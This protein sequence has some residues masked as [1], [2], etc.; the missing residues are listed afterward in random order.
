MIA[1]LP[2][3]MHYHQFPK[4]RYQGS[5]RRLLPWLDKTF[6]K[7]E[8][9]SCLDIFGGTSSVSYLLKSKGKSVSYNDY[10]KSNA[11][12]AKAL[13]MNNSVK[14]N[15]DVFDSLFNGNR[16]PGL[17]TELFDGIFYTK[18][19]NIEIDTIINMINSSEA[20]LSGHKKDIA[21]FCLFQA[22]LMKRPFNLFH[23]ANLNLRTRK[24]KRSFGNHVTW[25]TS[26]K[27]LMNRARIEAN[28]AIFSNGKKHK[29]YNKDVLKLKGGYDL[30]YLDPPYYT[31]TNASIDIDYYKYYHF[32]EGISDYDSWADKIN[33]DYMSRPIL[34]NDSSFKR[35]TFEDDLRT[36]LDIHNESIIVL[37]YKR[38]G[39]PDIKA[40]RSI[41]NE[42]HNKPSLRSIEHKYSLNENN[43]HYRENLII[44]YPRK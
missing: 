5:K 43:G 28:E 35:N 39:F 29:A 8:F 11:I 40:L 6:D 25:E 19:E 34:R 38:P 23:R 36:L 12:C 33:Y 37:S 30:V 1:Y 9:E 24:V 10:M 4:T 44:A 13:I 41:I 15:E 18:E 3:T 7:I 2:A 16:Q 14:L 27:E 42:T 21:M 31:V 17:V 26:I 32:L 22:L 20:K